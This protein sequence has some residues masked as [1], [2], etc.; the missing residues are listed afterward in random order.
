MLRMVERFRLLATVL[1]RT[2]IESLADRCSIGSHPSN[3]LVLEEPTVSR[4]HYEV[5]VDADG[6]KVVDLGSRNGTT[7][8]GVR[9]LGA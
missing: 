4:F 3:D 5:R 6:A 2:K 9:V 1:P 8:D 7:L